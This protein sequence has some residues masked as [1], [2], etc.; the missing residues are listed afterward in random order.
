M[1]RP[2]K[3]PKATSATAVATAVMNTIKL[4]QVPPAPSPFVQS[5][6]GVITILRRVLLPHLLAGLG[7]FLLCF[8]ST[9]QLAIA[10]SPLPDVFKTVLRVLFLLF[11]GAGAFFFAM[12]AAG[13]YAL[14]LACVGWDNFIEDL[15]DK[16]QEKMVSHLDTMQDSIAKD[17]A[18]VLVRG[19]VGEVFEAVRRQPS[20]LPR[21]VVTLTLG[22]LMLVVRAVLTARVL[23]LAGTTIKVSKIFAGKA[24]LVGAV[25]L[26]LRFFTTIVLWL[27]YAAG[28]GAALLNVMLVWH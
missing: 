23:K 13:L 4:S 12:I 7:L 28:F 8:F 16:V 24:T 9:H 18:K 15:I 19:S 5:V 27:V 21:W 22:V 26:N 14:R 6:W 20:K 10:P 1:Y 3:R 25:F 11:Y 17:Q 2:S